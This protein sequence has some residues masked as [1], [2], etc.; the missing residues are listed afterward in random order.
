MLRKELYY[1]HTKD[2]RTREAY[3]HG[4]E[5]KVADKAYLSPHIWALQDMHVSSSIEAPLVGM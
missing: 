3:I 2:R 5:G 1:K 4:K